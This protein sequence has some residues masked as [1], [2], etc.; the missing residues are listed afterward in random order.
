MQSKITFPHAIREIE[1][2]WIHLADGTRLAAR[3]WL[4]ED[5]ETQPVPAIFEYLP[6]R[7][8][9]GT[10]FRDALQHP[11]FAGHGYACVRV[12][13][14]GTGDA[15]G[16]MLDEYL[17]QE[18]DDAREVL[19]WI[20]AQ[21]WCTGD[22]GMMGI[23]W[24]G[25]NGLQVAARRPPELKA[26]ITLCSTDDRYADDIHYAGGCMLA[27]E[28][29]PWASIMFAYN[30]L[31]PDPRFVGAHWRAMWHQ[32]MA[33]TPP[34]IE[35]WL[36][37]QRRDEFWQ[38]GSVCEDFSAITCPVYAIGG[39]A[40]GY[41][42]AVPR[43]L[44]GLT[45][46]RKGLIGPWPHMY[47]ELEGKPGPTIGFLQEAL[48]WWDHW[49]KGEETGIMDEP[50]LRVWMQE[51][52]PPDDLP[53]E[54]PGRWVAEERWPTPHGQPQVYYLANEALT[55]TPAEG[56]PISLLGHPFTGA[57]AGLWCAYGR[58]G[59][60]PLDQRAEDGRS[61]CF[62]SDPG[63]ESVEI[64]GFPEVTLKLTVDQPVAQVVVRLCDVAPNGVSTLVTRGVFNLTH[65]ESHATPSPLQPGQQYTVT[66]QLN[67][68][69]HQ[70]PAGHRWRV[71][72][73]PTYWPWLWPS[74]NPV[75]LSLFT[76]RD[77]RLDLPVR[78]PSND[79]ATLPPFGPA[80]G[81]PPLPVQVLRTPAQHKGHHYDIVQR[82][83]HHFDEIDAGRHL[84]LGNGI[85]RDA[86]TRNYFDLS[87]ADPC[88]AQVRCEHTISLK[89]DSGPHAFDIRVETVSTMSADK[90]TF[91]VTNVL[92]AYEGTV[93]VFAKTW[94]FAVPRDLV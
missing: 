22:I 75:T 36:T 9:D 14:R 55:E 74:P 58:Q 52:M 34:Y 60:L 71:A 92:E 93:R 7:K 28:H 42:N 51:S 41:T 11:Y 15:D 5:A 31:P 62:T 59:D 12:D 24:G 64:L 54:R 16:L 83:L 35:A 48:R 47:P 81:A 33:E 77:C 21:P 86:T 53:A 43:L 37:H 49:L 4:P 87:E 66:V 70:L 40:D 6:Y 63:T 65:R 10:A 18:Q 20:A 26:V 85:E 80:E 90:E 84:I 68:I 73:S 2:C 23:S 29:L 39:W 3:I 67:A 8:T 46:P 72:I 91:Y 88:S 38:H 17:R 94:D 13:M 50:M 89:R 79:D 57:D 61:M 56:N 44:T 30:A 82:H 1:N 45:A 27:L 78:A 25:F 69:A 32:R 76:G 19:T